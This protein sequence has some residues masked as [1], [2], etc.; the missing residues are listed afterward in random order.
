MYKM[1]ISFVAI[2]LLLMM[3][4]GFVSSETIAGE[5]P[6][7]DGFNRT[8]R[9]R[10]SKKNKG[11]KHCFKNPHLSCS[12]NK[13]CCTHVHKKTIW[14]CPRDSECGVVVKTCEV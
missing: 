9:A 6:F 13:K 5:D 7:T 1:K 2:A 4:G 3:S 10:P 12:N 11:R 8:L 14:C